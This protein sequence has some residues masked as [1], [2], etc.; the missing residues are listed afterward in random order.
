M[1]LRGKEI[2]IA[3]MGATGSGKSTFINLASD[4]ALP[5]G[6]G[7]ESCTSEVRT[8]RPFLLNGRIITLIDTPGST[9]RIVATRTFSRPSL[10]TYPTLMNKV[11]SSAGIIYMHRISDVRIGGTSKPRLRNVLI[12]TNMW[13][14]VDPKIGEARERELVSNDK[15]FKPVLEK[16]ARILRHDGAQAGAH[17]ILRHLVNSQAATLR[18]QH[19]IVNEHRDLAHTAA[20]AELTRDGAAMRAKD[21][22]TRNELQEEVEK[23]REEIE[24]AR[25]DA[26]RMAAEFVAEKAR[27]Q[28]RIAE[29][30]A[31]NRRYVAGSLRDYRIRSWRLAKKSRHR[32]SSTLDGNANSIAA[33]QEDAERK[34]R[35]LEEERTVRSRESRRR[36]NTGKRLA[37]EAAEREG[38]ER[39]KN[40]KLQEELAR[41]RRQAENARAA[42]EKRPL[43][44]D[45]PSD[46]RPTTFERPSKED[47]P[48]AFGLFKVIKFWLGV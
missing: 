19:E 11:P 23:K 20:G 21:D 10:R 2:R 17:G 24:R 4:S 6:N 14:N 41:A 16:G 8:S 33:Q 29:M 43:E 28:S 37:A 1:A 45:P 12:V 44:K 38:A 26:E 48:S 31:E 18:I 3:V 46:F 47:P 39:Q 32:R 35:L 36:R 27:L 42:Q 13:S 40:A 7:L 30:E 15:F 5:V 34:A 9:I 22:E 25:R